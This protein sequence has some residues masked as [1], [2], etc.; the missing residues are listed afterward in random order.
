M[1]EG[2]IA[3]ARW[4]LAA[5]AALVLG[6]A[7]LAL[8]D[9]GL[10]RAGLDRA[11]ALRR[12]LAA[13]TLVL[14]LALPLA[15]S[16]D[17]TP[18]AP[19]N[20]T[21]LVVEQYL[22]GNLSGLSAT[23]LSDALAWRGALPRMLTAPDGP[24]AQALAAVLLAAATGRALWVA[25]AALRLRGVVRRARPLRRAG[26]LRIA[27]SSDCAVPFAASG[28]WRHHVVLPARLALS[29]DAF[30]LALAHELQH[31]RQGDPRFETGVALLS[32]LFALNP[33]FWALARRMRRLREHGCDAACIARPGIDA[34]AYALCLLDV[35]R[36]AAGRGGPGQGTFTVPLLGRRQGSPRRTGSQLGH[37]IEMIADGPGR[38]AGRA[39]GAAVLGGFCAA[40]VL[41]AWT[42]AAPGEW[43][44]ARL[45]LSSVTNLERLDAINT[46][47]RPPLR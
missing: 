33:A 5:N 22:R 27:L 4:L 10:C 31:V 28:P 47:A 35:A 26:R 43:S 2:L 41:G 29:P 32:P 39:T 20:A 21:E 45:M 44:Q 11:W 23:A 15:L 24:V 30:R 3:A 16:Q 7:L 1:G 25:G 46:L 37:R 42:L 18:A 36:R 40:C 12:R 19:V 38:P 17:W 6:M 9:A 34:R 8:A 13:S 14:A